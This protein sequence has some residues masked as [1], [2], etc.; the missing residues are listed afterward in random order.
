MIGFV[1]LASMNVARPRQALSTA[2]GSTMEHSQDTRSKLFTLACKCRAPRL[3]LLHSPAELQASARSAHKRA[4]LHSPQA[5]SQRPLSLSITARSAQQDPPSDFQSDTQQASGTVQ[6]GADTSLP[7]ASL[8]RSSSESE[9]GPGNWRASADLATAGGCPALADLLAQLM[10]T[11]GHRPLPQDLPSI[12]TGL[13]QILEATADLDSL[14][15]LVE[16]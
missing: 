9:S 16:N 1:A 10:Q 15:G 5:V 13:S 12:P 2:F 11:A 14:A 3:P 6:L 8:P 7:T 4:R